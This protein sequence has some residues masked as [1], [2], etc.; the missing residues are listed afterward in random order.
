MA[1]N[2]AYAIGVHKEEALLVF[3]SSEQAV[4]YAIWS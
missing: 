1:V 4:R 2:L 3:S